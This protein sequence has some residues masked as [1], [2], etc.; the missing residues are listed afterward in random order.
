MRYV[1]NLRGHSLETT[2]SLVHPAQDFLQ[3]VIRHPEWSKRSG[4]E[5]AHQAIEQ[6]RITRTLLHQKVGFQKTLYA[7][8]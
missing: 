4:Q 6:Q 1:C 8:A 3:V 5:Q 2:G 7:T